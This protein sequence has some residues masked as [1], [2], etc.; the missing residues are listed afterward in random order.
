[1]RT[2]QR[3]IR[4]LPVTA[5]SSS[6]TCWSGRRCLVLIT[7][8]P[9]TTCRSTG[10]CRSVELAKDQSYVLYMLQQDEL[11]RLIFPLGGFTKAQVRAMAAKR[12]LAT[13]Y[14]PESMDICFIPDHDYRRF[15]HEERP[16]TIRPGPITDRYGNVLGQHNGLPLYT[17]GQRK[18]LGITGKQ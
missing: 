2:A 14:K 13:A 18:G 10:S 9:G 3:R 7:S 12:G 16:E 4:A 17:I 6:A 5:T 8:R 1:M 11:S 15:L